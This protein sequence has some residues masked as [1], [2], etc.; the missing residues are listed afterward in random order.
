VS[1]VSHPHQL[2]VLRAERP[3]PPAEQP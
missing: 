3:A 1:E 2:S